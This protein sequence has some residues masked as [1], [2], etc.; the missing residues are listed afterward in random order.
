MSTVSSSST[1]P[2]QRIWNEAQPTLEEIRHN[3]GSDTSPR[4]TRVGKLDAELLDQEL[5]QVLQEPLA[6]ALGLI[7]VRFS[8]FKSESEM[9]S[10]LQSAL[11]TRFDPELAL[12]IQLTLYKFSVWDTGASYGARLQGLKYAIPSWA[13]GHLPGQCL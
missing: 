12:L 10:T 6:K 4:I 2:W 8:G 1:T 11:R 3:V 5:V 7:N 13:K 9:M